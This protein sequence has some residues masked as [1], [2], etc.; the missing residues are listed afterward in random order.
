MASWSCPCSAEGRLPLGLAQLAGPRG[1]GSRALGSCAHPEQG[2]GQA[3]HCFWA[4]SMRLLRLVICEQHGRLTVA[5]LDRATL[6]WAARPPAPQASPA[7]PAAS[8]PTRAARS[9]TVPVAGGHRPCHGPGALTYCRWCT[10]TRA[11]PHSSSGAGTYLPASAGCGPRAWREGGLQT[12]P[13]TLVAAKLRATLCSLTQWLPP[14][15]CP[16]GKARP[17][18]ICPQRGRVCLGAGCRPRERPGQERG[19]LR[20][21]H[22]RCCQHPL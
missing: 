14:P 15:D 6:A 4:W 10:E 21:L 12:E 8:V 7:A 17:V 19:G 22:A 11:V 16:E 20:L 13:Q 1:V 18:P 5:R 3:T 2:V 9:L